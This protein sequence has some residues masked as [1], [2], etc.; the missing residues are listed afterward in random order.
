M[1]SLKALRAFDWIAIGAVLASLAGRLSLL[2]ME[3]GTAVY[4]AIDVAHEVL[5][6]V[7]IIWLSVRAMQATTPPHYKKHSERQDGP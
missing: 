3:R 4:E 2:L 6:M 7:A 5:V 1:I